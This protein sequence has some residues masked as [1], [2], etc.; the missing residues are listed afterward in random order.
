MRV[1]ITGGAGY[2][3]TS[4]S[5]RLV[6]RGDEVVVVDRFV[7]GQAS[8][9][10]LGKLEVWMGDV[11]DRRALDE[12]SR[13]VDV[14]VHLAFVSNDPKYD[15]PQEIS[16]S[17][18]I[19]GSL[20]MFRAARR[21]GVGR[22]IVLSSCSVYGLQSG[23]LT[24][25]APVAPLT[26][27]AR[28]KLLVESLMDDELDG[29]DS[30]ALRPATVA[31]LSPQM[32]LDLLLNRMV[33]QA[34]YEGKLSVR[35]PASWRPVTS[36]A[37][38]QEVLAFLVHYPG[39]FAGARFNLASEHR[40]V[41]AWADRVALHMGVPRIPDTSEDAD[42]RSYQV[43]CDALHEAM[44]H[45]LSGV[46]DEVIEGVAEFLRSRGGIELLEHPSHNRLVAQKGHD[47]GKAVPL[48][49]IA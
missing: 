40:T 49:R 32:R 41:G 21:A 12:L 45:R 18:N 48:E 46:S 3:G 38:L 34:M 19:E 16:R 15:L 26:D 1:L 31:G 8:V 47:F 33:A 7:N 22:V 44:D 29:V 6:A 5:Q 11:R 23:S 2:I 14:V 4:L 36:M 42:R 35:S 9:S 24:E 28:H 27:Y 43:S 37:H 30:V 20:E 17:V 39:T 10:P 13:S 25:S